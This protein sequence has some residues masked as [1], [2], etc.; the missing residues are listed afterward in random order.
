MKFSC[1]KSD[2]NEALQLVIK[3][4]DPKPSVP[5]LSCI[6]IKLA[7]GF[8]EFH[9]NNLS[10]GIIAKIPVAIEIPGEVVVSGRRFV[11]FV[12]NMPDDTI[13]FNED[14]NTLQIISG[15]ANVTLLTMPIDDFPKVKLPDSTAT[16]EIDSATLNK[17][18]RET[19]FAA[20]QK[21]LSRPLF[22]GVVFKIKKDSLAVAATNTHR[23]SF[24]VAQN[25]NFDNEAEFVVPANALKNLQGKISDTK[26]PVK[27]H[28]CQKFVA[29]DVDNFLMTARLIEGEFPP[30]DRL[31]YPDKGVTQV[32]VDV[33]EF[34]NAL[35]L[36]ALMAKEDQYNK[37]KLVIAN[38]QIG[39]SANSDS[40]GEAVKFVDA[41]VTGFDL[42]TYYNINYLLDVLRILDTK[43]IHIDFQGEYAPALFSSTENNFRY[44]ATPVR[45]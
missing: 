15:G 23:I 34:R 33:R 9:G 43:D 30:F 10:T 5:I 31:I 18:I 28:Y 29:F 27:I 32:T 6:Y 22:T 19:V 4:V 21:N 40:V 7:D 44:V 25:L 38:R 17:L 16:F 2:L 11:D 13:T 12:R 24:D 41:I 42:T 39:I 37:V 1:Y 26:L 3:A 45:G 36:V 14:G 8:A 20:E 35:E